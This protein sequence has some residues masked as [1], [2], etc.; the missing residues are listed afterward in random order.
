MKP[1][2][3]ASPKSPANRTLR[4]RLGGLATAARHSPMDYTAAARA[5]ANGIERFLEQ[6]PT[7]LPEGERMR[8]AEAL[9][10]EHYARLQLKSAQARREKAAGKR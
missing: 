6:V 2:A 8:R 4:A 7:D 3:T 10:K 9:R 1:P 5:R